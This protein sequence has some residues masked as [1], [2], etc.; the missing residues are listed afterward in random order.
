MAYADLHR[1]SADDDASTVTYHLNLGL[2]PPPAPARR[3]SLADQFGE[4]DAAL[5]R[6]KVRREELRQQILSTGRVELVG[7]TW[8]VVLENRTSRRLD[9]ELLIERFGAETVDACRAERDG[10]YLRT[11][12]L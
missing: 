8:S 3:V 4:V 5:R 11:E 9:Q 10:V 2:E 7:H 1:T 6:L 12:R